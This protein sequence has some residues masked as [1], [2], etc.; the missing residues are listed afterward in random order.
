VNSQQPTLDAPPGGGSVAPLGFAP[1][2]LSP[3]AGNT[4]ASSASS[5]GALPE[6]PAASGAQSVFVTGTA[7]NSSGGG[8]GGGSGSNA[9]AA[10]AAALFAQ[11]PPSPAAATAASSANVS[12]RAV[13]PRTDAHNPFAQTAP[14]QQ[15]Q[16]PADVMA[17]VRARGPSLS[18]PLGPVDNDGGGL[19]PGGGG[20][21]GRGGGGLGDLYR[22][23]APPGPRAVTGDDG[24][25][26]EVN[27]QQ[28]SNALVQVEV[29][30][31]MLVPS[32]VGRVA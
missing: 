12:P 23:T 13:S 3:W 27:R 10:A 26:G 5:S 22:N 18:D 31:H 9:A 1:G 25:W 19:G 8:G 30:G 21:G 6:P 29:M 28:Q 17:G 4:M 32:R 20:G 2:G 16:P 15:Q 24:G 11:P 14:P 7:T